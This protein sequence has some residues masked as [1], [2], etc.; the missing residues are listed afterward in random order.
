MPKHI[1]HVLVIKNVKNMMNEN[2]M[3]KTLT[4][5]FS[6]FVIP[7]KQNP[8]LQIKVH[9]HLNHAAKTRNAKAMAKKEFASG[10]KLKHE[11][12]NLIRICIL[13]FMNNVEGI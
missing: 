2:K 6:T 13:I 12:V 4:L 9:H 7:G 11:I 3:V 10:M 5:A 1:Q 8:K